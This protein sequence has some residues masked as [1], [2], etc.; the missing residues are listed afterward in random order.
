[1]AVAW[2]VGT[3]LARRTAADLPSKL[4]AWLK[5]FVPGRL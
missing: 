5:A 3:Y 2:T 4:R 1:M